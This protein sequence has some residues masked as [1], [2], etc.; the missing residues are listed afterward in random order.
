[1]SEKHMSAEQKKRF[2]AAKD[3]EWGTVTKSGA[4]RLR[5]LE[6]SRK[7]RQTLAHR[8]MKCRMLLDEKVEEGGA[9][10]EKARLILL[11]H[12]DPDLIR[13]VQDGETT[14]STVSVNSLHLALQLVASL[15][16]DL[17]LGDIRGAFIDKIP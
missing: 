9:V 12:L 1:M 14:S 2:H 8:I 17:Q 5:S 16:A 4:I 3:M 7:I 6:D 11:G 13:L 15:Q 10:R